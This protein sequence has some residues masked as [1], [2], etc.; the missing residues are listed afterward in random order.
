MATIEG[1]DG[2]NGATLRNAVDGNGVPL[3]D[4]DRVTLTTTPG[5]DVTDTLSGRNRSFFDVDM[6]GGN[7]TLLASNMNWTDDRVGIRIAVGDIDMGAGNDSL[8]LFRSEVNVIDMG[9]GRDTLAL[10]HAG[11]KMVDM[12]DGADLVRLTLPSMSLSLAELAQIQKD[13]SQP[14]ILDG[15]A[16]DDTLNLLGSWGPSC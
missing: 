10:D 5:V 7:D 11:A 13:P 4:P 2:T 3:R 8:N 6:K 1:T 9:S 12:G 14:M 16:Q 15:G